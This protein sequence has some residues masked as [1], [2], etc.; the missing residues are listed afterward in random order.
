MF[1][2]F[3]VADGESNLSPHSPPSPKRKPPPPSME[4]H[5]PNVHRKKQLPKRQ[6]P[7]KQCNGSQPEPNIYQRHYKTHLRLSHGQKNDSDCCDESKTNKDGSSTD[8][9]SDTCKKYQLRYSRRQIDVLTQKNN[10]TGG[11]NE[12]IKKTNTHTTITPK[13]IYA[14]K[15]R[16]NDD[17]EKAKTDL[18]TTELVQ[19]FG[20]Y[21][22]F[23]ITHNDISVECHSCISPLVDTAGGSHQR[24]NKVVTSNN[25][26]VDL[27]VSNGEIF[28]GKNI[29]TKHLLTRS[30]SPSLILYKI[31]ST[32][33]EF[34]SNEKKEQLSEFNINIGP[35]LI[36]S[37]CSA[38]PEAY[39]K[40]P[41]PIFST[42]M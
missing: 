42:I 31:S 3:V 6:K 24:T 18:L 13:K 33:P 8:L 4:R 14:K 17:T 12:R 35:E 5:S 2:C 40:L 30:Y 22:G 39:S 1:V 26:V 29:H 10:E 23:P 36:T 16:K 27:K 28:D 20:H 11:M 41:P 38:S 19:P 9:S 37:Y 21:L 32:E 34:M 25:V 15:S 7:V